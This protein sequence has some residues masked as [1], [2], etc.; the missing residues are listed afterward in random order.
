MP[1]KLKRRLLWRPS[2][3]LIISVIALIMATS[4][5]GSAGKSM[6]LG[7]KKTERAAAAGKPFITGAHIVPNTIQTSDLSRAAVT[8]LKGD[9][10]PAGPQGQAGPAG[11]QGPAGPPGAGSTVAFASRDVGGSPEAVPVG[12]TNAGVLNLDIPG[13]TAGYVSSSGVITA[14]GPSRLVATADVT[15]RNDS[16]F[17]S[18][19]I[20]RLARFTAGQGDQLPF[21]I[22]ADSQAAAGA[23]A[24]LPLTAG[25]DVG[26]GSYNVRV[27]C[28]TF[29]VSAPIVFI[30]G[31]LTVTLS[32]S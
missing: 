14:T 32:P 18:T 15:L 3:A 27:Q 6:V 12:A 8:A 4:G 17:T 24:T 16:S 11:A 7:H 10:G 19:F 23:Q 21:G 22:Q 2:P 26:P 1:S 29:G 31:N 20:C 25:L 13:G 5:V 28:F 9:Q 30:R